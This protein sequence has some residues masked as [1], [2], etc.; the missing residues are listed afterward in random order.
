MIAIRA[1]MVVFVA[2]L[3]ACNSG[4][5]LAPGATDMTADASQPL[6]CD[7]TDDPVLAKIHLRVE[8]VSGADRYVALPDVSNAYPGPRCTA[9]SI[10]QGGKPLGL[11][12]GFQCVCE[13]AAPP[14]EY[15][16][17]YRRLAAGESFELAVWDG[18][19]L[20][21]CDQPLDC[22]SRGW[23]DSPPQT[24]QILRRR[25]ASGGDYTVAVGV[26]AALPMSCTT[27]DGITYGCSVDA[28]LLGGTK[29]LAPMC[30]TTT[31]ATASF[32]LAVPDEHTVTVELD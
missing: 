31:T 10:D 5:G 23:P 14:S 27:G 19:S 13:C 1:S 12:R 28:G 20:I 24:E 26:E 3:A 16:Q 9:F 21:E 4:N 7:T 11:V 22:S 32:T 30:P 2:S 15:R 18:R 25:Q 29:L 17:E 6:M 8:N